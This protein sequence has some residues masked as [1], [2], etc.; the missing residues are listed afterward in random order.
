VPKQD[1]LNALS[2]V[3]PPAAAD[4]PDAAARQQQQQQ[5]PDESSSSSGLREI[6]QQYADAYLANH[7]VS[8]EQRKVIEAI[9]TCRTFK[10]GWHVDVCTT[11]GHAEARANSCGNRHCPLCQGKNRFDWVDAR[12]NDLLP[13]QYF[14][15]VFTLPDT[16]FPFCLS[17]Q[18]VVYD[19][20]FHSAAD[21]LKAFGKDEQ[22]L[23]AEKMGF[24][25][26]LHT[27]GQPLNCH[28]HVHFVVPAGGLDE[29]GEW[30]W[31]TYTEQNFLFPVHALAKVFRGKFIA[32]L[33]Q[34]YTDGELAFP[35]QLA[36][37]EE[38]EAFEAWLDELVSKNWVVYA[39]A[40]FSGPLQVLR[41]VSRYT[42]RVAISNSRI[43]SIDNGVIRFSY[44]NYKKK[45]KCN[46]D[47]ELWEEMELPVE[48]FMQRF[49]YHV[50]PKGYH[51]IRYYG[52]LSGSQKAVWGQAWSELVF[53]EECGLPKVDARNTWE[54]MPCPACEEG[55]MTTVIVVNK[56]GRIIFGKPLVLA[57][58]L[59]Q[60]GLDLGDSAIPI[61]VYD[62]S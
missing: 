44:K 52:F 17:N 22:W 27:W 2:A 20:L 36:A 30:V 42:H 6:F 23:G 28:P 33:K 29:G 46:R 4:R 50:L 54:G 62:T 38:K 26:V 31:P 45:E 58:L 57:Q 8:I 9:R 55:V 16:I 25:G 21:T 14:H 5:V 7:A 35:G 12:V 18:K 60:L 32:G 15:A 40:P 56:H 10:A 34:A 53:E 47:E 51:R 19:L 24:F 3:H 49:L 13:V 43:L 37:L 61:N 48:T 39:K 1:A 59:P 11:C 41:Y